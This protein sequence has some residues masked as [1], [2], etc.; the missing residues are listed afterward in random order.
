MYIKG[1][2]PDRIIKYTD[3]ETGIEKEVYTAA[4]GVISV[5]DFVK[6]IYAYLKLIG[7]GTGD[8]DSFKRR[9][10]AKQDL[11][12]RINT[13]TGRLALIDDNSNTGELSEDDY[14]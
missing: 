9:E 4:I 2:N 11:I 14:N 12:N 13:I 5:S 3:P 8:M 10:A 7:E 1:L 6:L